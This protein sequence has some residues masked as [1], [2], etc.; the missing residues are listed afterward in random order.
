MGRLTGIRALG[1]FILAASLSGCVMPWAA[2]SD[3]SG[4][5]EGALRIVQ[6]SDL[7]V[8]REKSLFAQ[9]MRKINDASPDILIFT[10]DQI[11]SPEGLPL[12]EGYLAS[13]DVDCP[14]YAIMGN[15]EYWGNVDV[16]EYRDALGALGVRLLVNQQER[17]D[18]KGRP[19]SIYGLDDYLGGSPSFQAYDVHPEDLNIV[20]GH[21]PAL[22]DRL[23][24]EFASNSNDFHM[25]S[26]HTH[27]GQVTFFGLPLYLPEGS[28]AYCAGAYQ[29]GNF[30]L[31]VSKG[32]GNSTVDFRLFADP[33]IE[34]IEL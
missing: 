32:V 17:I 30:H 22:F 14:T 20:L 34:I 21:C 18:I 24:S 15:W 3:F 19:V 25:F 12:L 26:G 10:G 28:G 23:K 11:E 8:T 9:T 4:G 29:E 5:A 33:E 6:V 31:F 16:Q 27:G 13:I 1:L 7:H 2:E